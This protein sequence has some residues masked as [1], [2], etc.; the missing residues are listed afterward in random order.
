ME[1]VTVN[2]PQADY[3][4]SVFFVLDELKHMLSAP[5][6]TALAVVRSYGAH[7]LLAHQ[8][9]GDLDSCASLNPVEVRGAII[10]NTAL[11]IIYRINDG[12]FAAKLSKAAGLKKTFTEATGKDGDMDGHQ[13]SW[14]EQQTPF[15]N[16]D[17]LTHLPLPSDRPGQASAGV[18]LG[19][20]NAKLFHIGPMA[21]VGEMPQAQAAPPS[22]KVADVVGGPI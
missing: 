14:R 3:K 7:F 21:A 4:K 12:D 9:L 1:V 11:K 2:R 22:I 18:L 16:P 20:E 17:L 5:T 15:L 6:L 19:W 10:D 8:S 13:G